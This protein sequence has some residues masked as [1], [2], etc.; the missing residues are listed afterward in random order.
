VGTAA[1]WEEL[2]T[3]NF[4]L[5]Q[6]ILELEVE[7]LAIQTENIDFKQ[8]VASLEWVAEGERERG[9]EM[10]KE[11][12]LE[13]E[14]HAEKI[15]L[16]EQKVCE[17]EQERER[18]KEEGVLVSVGGNVLDGEGSD[19]ES[20]V[21]Q[22]A[23]SALLQCEVT[24]LQRQLEKRD[25]SISDLTREV[26]ALTIVKNG[27]KLSE[28]HT[29]LVRMHNANED[30]RRQL[31]ECNVAAAREENNMQ[32][33]QRLFDTVRSRDEQ[34]LVA[35]RARR[36]E[37]QKSLH[38][39]H[40]R[41][42][43]LIQLTIDATNECYTAREDWE[44]IVMCFE[45]ESL[46]QL[47]GTA[48][49]ATAANLML[50][51]SIHADLCDKVTQ[52]SSSLVGSGL[53]ASD[54]LDMKVLSVSRVEQTAAKERAAELEKRCNG[55]E[56]TMSWLQDE[57]DSETRKC[58]DLQLMCVAYRGKIQ[59]LEEQIEVFPQEYAREI[60]AKEQEMADRDSEFENI[61]VELETAKR[62]RQREKEQYEKETR[63]LKDA[64]G[65]E[66]ETL[67]LKAAQLKALEFALVAE[68]EALRVRECEMLG[69]NA[70]ADDAHKCKFQEF[71]HTIARL[72]AEMAEEL[73]RVQILEAEN[74]Y[75][76][77]HRR[78]LTSKVEVLQAAAL[79]SRHPAAEV[80]AASIHAD[81]TPSHCVSAR[82]T[83]GGDWALKVM[84]HDL[85]LG[86]GSGG[87]EDNVEVF[88]RVLQNGRERVRVVRVHALEMEASCARFSNEL[89]TARTRIARLETRLL[90]AER[91]R[92]VAETATGGI[93]GGGGR[94]GGGADVFRK[95][96]MQGNVNKVVE[97]YQLLKEEADA[98]R[99]AAAN[100]FHVRTLTHTHTHT[101]ISTLSRSHFP[102]HEHTHYTYMHARI[103]SNTL[104]LS[105]QNIK[106]VESPI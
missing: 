78:D 60:A 56:T 28:A 63:L 51:L 66:E 46:S 77:Q 88:Q 104:S 22:N 8:L 32:D 49:L 79:Q 48:T 71:E 59:V 87:L 58:T 27:R 55:L 62:E 5:K 83:G 75:Q 61:I 11:R 36:K 105:S 93:R 39:A 47:K 4:K 64:C 15:L 9:E 30:L 45:S 20:G 73:G 53:M 82:D 52:T 35:L 97:M 10:E 31:F 92:V 68:T 69:K 19:S 18:R 96:V 37:L 38:A 40:T 23:Q 100:A 98:G 103:F 41:A 86:R 72:E 12:D 95:V 81:G 33:K 42:T 14:E 3:E 34:E 54:T 43:E 1:L 7:E 44:Q 90:S 24:N 21:V 6:R 65:E 25:K 89:H 80:H 102:T 16:L 29:E 76:N 74:S 50:E 17:L 13:R 91:A 26:D 84:G 2:Q 57:K 94:G 106:S 99:E 101:H 70:A 85:M 67:R